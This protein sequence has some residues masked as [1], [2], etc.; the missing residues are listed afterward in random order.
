MESKGHHAGKVLEIVL[1]KEAQRAVQHV[2]TV[3][4]FAADPQR[5]GGRGQHLVAPFACKGQRL[6]VRHFLHTHDFPY[7]PSVKVPKHAPPVC[8]APAPVRAAAVAAQGQAGSSKSAGQCRVGRPVRP[9]PKKKETRDALTVFTGRLRHVMSLPR[10][11]AVA[12][13]QSRRSAE[14]MVTRRG[15][16]TPRT[17]CTGSGGGCGRG[18]SEGRRT[19]VP[20][21]RKEGSKESAWCLWKRRGFKCTSHTGQLNTGGPPGCMKVHRCHTGS[22]EACCK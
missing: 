7:P 19:E 14:H 17:A 12:D 16:S 8:E 21:P 13:K 11:G 18:A 3:A 5:S 2:G 9:P 10:E 15:P 1:A 22:W 20:R 4:P 6:H